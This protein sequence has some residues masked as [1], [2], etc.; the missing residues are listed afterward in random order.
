MIESFALIK[1]NAIKYVLVAFCLCFSF[2]MHAQSVSGSSPVREKGYRGSVSFTDLELIWMGFDTSHGYMFNGHN[3]LGAG[4]GLFM[5]PIYDLPMYGH[6]FIDYHAYFLKKRSTP[7]A[8]IKLGYC[9]SICGDYRNI[10]N[11]AAELE[12][13]VGW[14]WALRNNRGLNLSVGAAV[15][16]YGKSEA[17]A[18]PKVSFAFEF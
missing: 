9:F 10:F 16:I 12:P 13:N 4:A 11:R 5:A 18:L 1:K 15:F 14:S 6:L 2:C 8:G 17:V 3:Y 7:S